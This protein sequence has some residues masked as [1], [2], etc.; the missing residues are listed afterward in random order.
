LNP[1]LSEFT[2][3][4]IAYKQLVFK[5]GKRQIA[6]ELP[7]QWRYRSSAD[8]VKLLPPNDSTADAVIKAVPLTAPRPLDDKG[9]AAVR[10]HFMSAIPPTAQ[11]VNVVSESLNTVPLKVA[12]CEITATYQAFGEVFTRRALYLNLP[13][14]HVIFRLTARKNEFEGLWRT[15]RGSILSWQ[16]IEPAIP[17]GPRTASK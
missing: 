15:L 13:D 2:A 10:D 14:T 11:N 12:N 9:I 8:S 1:T 7:S 4:G 16:W 5:D 17:A 6:Y 3:E